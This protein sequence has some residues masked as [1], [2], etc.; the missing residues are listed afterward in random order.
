MV[1]HKHILNYISHTADA[2]CIHNKDVMVTWV[3]I[4]HDLGLIYGIL[5]P[6]IQG[7]SCYLMTPL[8]FVQQPVRWLKA[9]SKYKGTLTSGPNFS[10]DLCTDKVTEAD[11]KSID[12]SHL[13]VLLNGAEPVRKDTLL[14]FVEAFKPCG[15][16]LE[17][18]SPA[19]G[20]AEA[21]LTLNTTP[22]YKAPV[23]IDVIESDLQK[24]IV[25]TATADRT[26]DVHTFIGHSVAVGNN[27]VVIVNP[28][29]CKKCT[30]NEVGEIWIKGD[31]V[32][33][34]YWKR[35]KLSNTEFR[36]KINGDKTGDTYLRSGDL[37]FIK[38]SELFITGRHKDLI[39]IRGQ[40]YYPQDIEHITDHA[41]PALRK[42]CA[43]AFSV[44]VDREEKLIIVQEL[45][46]NETPVDTIKAII[47]QINQE[48]FD[49]F[50]IQAHALLFI[51]P[52][53]ICKTSSGK[54]QRQLCK[55]QFNNQLF[56]VVYKWSAKDGLE[57]LAKKAIPTNTALFTK[58]KKHTDLIALIA[59]I[60]KTDANT[61]VADEP[62]SFYGM[63][64]LKAV[65]I[66]RKIT[67]AYNLNDYPHLTY[68]YPSIDQ[69][70]NFISAQGKPEVTD[71]VPEVNLT[72]HQTIAITGMACRF[73]GAD[74]PAAFYE[75]LM[76]GKSGIQEIPEKR[77]AYFQLN[78]EATHLSRAG[79][80]NTV[81]DFDYRAF[82]LSKVE[83]MNMDPHQRLTLQLV[84]EALENAG[85]RHAAVSGKS[86]GVFIG[87]CTTD[88]NKLKVRNG[89]VSTGHSGTSA[90]A[91]IIANR[92][93]YFFNFKGPSLTIDT[94]CSSSLTAFHYAVESLKNGDCEIAIAGGVNLILDPHTTQ[95]YFN[96][97]MLSADCECKTFD[98]G[99]N[100]YVRGEGCG[101]VVLAT[102]NAV[103]AYNLS[104]I[105]TVAAT[106]VNQDGKSNGI[107]APN[108]PAQQ[109]VII[110][111]L[112]KA[113]LHAND[114]D[115]IET[116]GTGTKLGDPIEYHSLKNVFSARK[117]QLKLGALKTN[118]GHL[119]AA[120][121]IAGVI[122]SVLILKYNEI[123]PNRNLQI[124]NQYIEFDDKLV[125]LTKP[126]PFSPNGVK[127]RVMGISSFGFGGTN[128]HAILQGLN[129]AKPTNLSTPKKLILTSNKSEAG[130]KKQLKRLSDWIQEE[131]YSIAEIEHYALQNNQHFN[132]RGF[133]TVDAN[134][135][136]KSQFGSVLPHNNTA[137]IFSGQGSQ[138]AGMGSDLYAMY[139]T[140]KYAANECAALFNGY[141]KK[142]I[143][144]ILF[145]REENEAINE[146]NFTQPALFTFEYALCKLI[147]S[148]GIT[149]TV[150]IGH[151]IGELTAAAIAGVI[152]LQDAVELV[153]YRGEYMH[154]THETGKMLAV[155][156]EKTAFETVLTNYKSDVVIAAIN[157]VDNY[158]LS[159]KTSAILEIEKQLADKKIHT[160]LLKTSNAFHSPL[161]N[162]AALKIKEKINTIVFK[163][164]SIPIVSTVTAKPTITF[165]TDYWVNQVLS[166]VQFYPAVETAIETCDINTFIEIGP[167]NSLLKFIPNPKNE[168]RTIAAQNGAQE[169]E[170][171]S[172]NKAIGQ[173][174]INGQP[175]LLEKFFNH[176]IQ[177]VQ[178][179]EPLYQFNDTPLIPDFF[180]NSSSMPI[181]STTNNVVAA[182]N[183]T[184]TSITTILAQLLRETPENLNPTTPFLEMGADSVI[185]IG[186]TR[187][188]AN[189]FGVEISIKMLFEELPTLQKLAEYITTNTTKKTIE[190]PASATPDLPLL[191]E[192]N[193]NC[194]VELKTPPNPTPQKTKTVQVN[195]DSITQ[196]NSGVEEIIQTQLR[197]MQTQLE[198]LQQNKNH[199]S[200]AINSE[201][202][203]APLNGVSIT[204]NG[205]ATPQFFSKEYIPPVASKMV[206]TTN[207]TLSEKQQ[208]ALDQLIT[209]YTKKTATSKKLTQ[210][211][212]A[213]LAD[214][215]A[216]VGFKHFIKEM[217]YPIIGKNTEKAYVTDADQNTYID[218]T[219]GF[220]VHLFGHKPPQIIAA[221]QRELTDGTELGPRPAIAGEVAQ[222]ITKLTG[223][224]RV[225]FTNSGTEAIMTAIRLVRAKRKK[226]KIVTFSSAY[227][228][229]SDATLG[230][231]NSLNPTESLSL[232]AGI[233][234]NIMK[235]LMVLKY[236]D[237]ESL[238][239]IKEHAAELAGVLVEPIQSRRP[240]LQPTAFLKELR[241][242]TA[243]F[244]IPLVFDE[245]VTGFRVAKGGVQELFDIKADLTT[246]GKIVGGGM[247]IGVVAGSKELMDAIDGGFWQYG[248]ASYPTVETTFFG[249]TFCQHPMALTAA[250]ETLKLLDA[251]GDQLLPWLNLRTE[252]LA[253]VLNAFF[254]ENEIPLRIVQFSSLFRFAYKGNMEVLFYYLMLNGLFV[255]EWR[256]FFL[257]A[258]HTDDDLN[259]IIHA[260][261][262]SV[263]TMQKAGFI[264]GNLPQDKQPEKIHYFQHEFIDFLAQATVNAPAFVPDKT[265]QKPVKNSPLSIYFFGNYP[266]EYS[267]DKYDTLIET[268]TFADEN[269]FQA[270]WLPERHFDQFGGFSPNP[271][272]VAAALA[273]KTKNIDL[274]AGSIVLP[275][276][277]TVRAVEEWAVV[278]NLSQGR[279]G[280]AIAS[281]W[282]P[283]DFIFNP[284]TFGEHRQKT[285]T[286]LK[287]FQRIWK[288][289]TFNAKNGKGDATDLTI[290]PHPK[291]KDVPLWLTIVNNTETYKKAGEL[292]VG[293]LT[294][295]MGQSLADL[296]KNIAVYHESLVK[297]G[298][299]LQKAKVTIL[300]HAYLA[301][302]DQTATAFATPYLKD[303]LK[304]TNLLISK[305]NNAE[306]SA[307]D[308]EYIISKAVN[309]YIANKSL[310]GSVETCQK[311]VDEWLKK[312]I[313]E[314]ALFLD[315]GIPK[316][317]IQQSFEFLQQLNFKF[318]QAST[319]KIHK[320]PINTAQK[321]LAILDALD[322][323]A[324]KAYYESFSL[325]VQGALNKPAFE[326]ALHSICQRHEALRTVIKNNEQ[327]VLDTLK[328]T[329]T[330]YDLTEKNNATDATEQWYQK[331][332]NTDFS[333]ED[334]PLWR[335][336]L[337]K[338]TEK[339]WHVYFT[340]HH[341]LFDGFSVGILLDELACY[342]NALLKNETTR[343]PDPVPFRK[344]IEVQSSWLK[345][346]EAIAQKKYWEAELN[347][348]IMPLNLP[349]TYSDANKND[350][351]SIAVYFPTSVYNAIKQV[352]IQN[353]CT[354][355]STLAAIFSMLMARVC[356]QETFILGMPVANRSRLKH[357]DR[358]IGYCS[359]VTPL[360]YTVNA[361]DTFGEHA[362]KCQERM[363]DVIE[364]YQD[365]PFA[366]LLE[367]VKEQYN[368]RNPLV[369]ATF[370]TERVFMPSFD[371]LGV[372]IKPKKITHV[373]FDLRVDILE[374]EAEVL[375]SIGYKKARFSVDFI[376]GLKD[377]FM[378]LCQQVVKHPT[379]TLK[380]LEMVS[381]TAE[382]LKLGEGEKINVSFEP[383]TQQI[384][385]AV[386]LNLEKN[387]VF[388]ENNQLTYAELNKKSERVAH[389]LIQDGVKK[390]AVIGIYMSR[391]VEF[392][393]T[394][395][396]ILKAGGVYLP[397]DPA[398]PEKRVEYIS[399]DSKADR[400]IANAHSNFKQ[401][402]KK[403]VL[404][405]EIEAIKTVKTH[406]LPTLFEND[407]AYIIYTS[408]ST[409][410]PKGVRV[411]HGGLA[412]LIFWNNTHY[413][414][415]QSTVAFQ[416]A[417]VS[418]DASV[419]ELWPYLAAGASVC[420]FPAEKMIDPKK[421]VT[422]LQK[423][424]V[425][426]AFIPTALVKSVV[427]ANWNKNN[428]LKHILT[429]GD[430][431]DVLPSKKLPFTIHNNYGPTEA[432]VVATTCEVTLGETPTI[433]RPITNTAVRIVDAYGRVTPVGVCGELQL[434]GKGVS[435][436]YLDDELTAK[437][438]IANNYNERAYRTG[439]RGYFDN[440]GNIHFAGRKDDQIQLRGYRI[441]LGEIET[442]LCGHET[443]QEAK[444]YLEIDSK[445]L[446]TEMVAYVYS[447]NKNLN[448]KALQFHLKKHI[449]PY[450]IPSVF[451][452]TTGPFE[453]N[454]H[455][456][457]DIERIK[458]QKKRAIDKKPEDAKP[459]TAVE[460]ELLSIWQQTLDRKNIALTDDFFLIGGHS[461]IAVE[462]IDQINRTF[463]AKFSISILITH[464]TIRQLANAI[465][466]KDE[467]IEQTI[468]PLN[469]N[470]NETTEQLLLFAPI[471]GN[472]MCYSSLAK[473]LA[474][475][476]YGIT[477]P[478]LTDEG[479]DIHHFDALVDF[480][481]EKIKTYFADTEKTVHI[482]GFC[483]GGLLALSVYQKLKNTFAFHGQ[484]LL[485]DTS[486]PDE[487]LEDNLH[488]QNDKHLLLDDFYKDL[489]VQN[490]RTVQ[491]L[492]EELCQLN[493]T[494]QISFIHKKAIEEKLVSEKTSEATVQHLFEAF[495][496]N[497]TAILPFIPEK[498]EEHILL[499]KAVKI[500]PN[501]LTVPAFHAPDLDWCN[502]NKGI[503][504]VIDVPGNH[505]TMLNTINS[506][507]L[508]SAIN[509]SLKTLNQCI[510]EH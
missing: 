494:Q 132:W 197:L 293:V 8:D 88:F 54:I 310:I 295:L 427:S 131:H 267:A 242:L 372:Q 280:L 333:L 255:W 264:T 190:Q 63:D 215:K 217:L 445:K 142:D 38:D 102:N 9:L 462:M 32:T 135:I 489:C 400:I 117:N 144:K 405:N 5:L 113:K 357:A 199:R 328:P 218:I 350:A 233:P 20:Q 469:A 263:W 463:N 115:Y 106:A 140:F 47:H 125:P 247:P 418:F 413:G 77:K 151:S 238:A 82:N 91:S 363:F 359:H 253:N 490:G 458:R 422:A 307:E 59:P 14:R 477:S 338:T 365:Y 69:I 183:T 296:E 406:E 27:A 66:S 219:M 504:E 84:W 325:T 248:D 348:A 118:V 121:G 347:E 175:I 103:K 366:E 95:D 282:H 497:A 33:N 341:I 309:E 377:G 354:S 461:L 373:P 206:E 399:N 143:R 480:Y 173:L 401:P 46:S 22:A 431:L 455:G 428:T 159:G 457:V 243:E 275:L 165:T 154:N 128:V 346:A 452:F 503:T 133:T 201:K 19:W 274:R 403:F 262:Q 444:V 453:Q 311:K 250:F 78:G 120:A 266:A 259:A 486:A 43:A 70:A 192:N 388:Y 67:V 302:D 137:F 209:D 342:Y 184:L 55:K 472:V 171:L 116:H 426:I 319:K 336:A 232:S 499:Y 227:H 498:F 13:K 86:V 337:L 166:A 460:A 456:K 313:T 438:F 109:E 367:D 281:G 237:L 464:N 65:E 21:T 483:A 194:P 435:P 44:D 4:H 478:F 230:I 110:S 75:L 40:N 450:M 147:M 287:D 161:L 510:L 34:G 221:L 134:G 303:Y 196:N 334:G 187:Q 270:F 327:V 80:L 122:K 467:A 222:L 491:D 41:H 451:N 93:S 368:T 384:E 425:E 482:G 260:I 223:N 492:A 395:L 164:A 17:M 74:N 329:I 298:H 207:R 410:K 278:D 299:G 155:F 356:E 104:P 304:K 58:N 228:G 10:F 353:G 507:Q 149:P 493:E 105:A 449:P 355:S 6:V 424:K 381:D 87:A 437:N 383:I 404:L 371:G 414:I 389:Y 390:G 495:Y 114:I 344:F 500:A 1:C 330:F 326:A 127:K 100:G 380:E 229:H 436:G 240:E 277:H 442:V 204:K 340:A 364:N 208:N 376:R 162:E 362:K 163:P 300:V 476:V 265:I 416:M 119:E 224:E 214:S 434:V 291:Q 200:A 294:N 256:N 186:A 239:I 216:A 370:N 484:L 26:E 396:G 471:G 305:G 345:S 241:A 123:P 211:H 316:N 245:M 124:P 508:A 415:S 7:I 90:A 28:V 474:F 2:Y 468:I 35:E 79:W 446:M 351:D 360:R 369:Q 45:R 76:Q 285:F 42:G 39:I 402:H 130:I 429:G 61:M 11:K 50:E 393:Y 62:L 249:G 193:T 421:V 386:Q 443:V 180:T 60:L 191:D 470:T 392:V 18:F 349:Y 146:T 98:N 501:L 332:A 252:K 419:W 172:F 379:L 129:K 323:E 465:A 335:V 181:N 141:L 375:F 473:E 417:A 382:M 16:T 92:V 306:M 85:I 145:E 94:A 440:A 448:A 420:Q 157:G 126:F 15:V 312:G 292:G 150:L 411:T 101:I 447:T 439:D 288:T 168:L 148:F 234:D 185:L 97:G 269:Y 284:T 459:S 301:A 48:L 273:V 31:M 506:P 68:D 188:I 441:E 83:A 317:D 81:F 182:K 261:K 505:N 156:A 286:Q 290:H 432:T 71:D 160:V 502:Y 409:G 30:A 321:Q 339:N 331:W 36:A 466:R 283:N 25:T 139:P 433:G 152:E 398:L 205:N 479:Q 343:L 89:S 268:A 138:Y 210:H 412:N 52:Q 236:D 37:G 153:Y 361:D 167:R 195:D 158:V 423:N 136:L 179:D 198:L 257:S 23:F 509:Q 385:K 107:T 72:T 170:C 96:A 108:G 314:V 246:Y 308:E 276:H 297:H 64:S 485:L 279:T 231:Y 213:T 254:E 56:D 111:A 51:Q 177:S 378:G 324:S 408:G 212:R 203:S 189:E 29:S 358:M 169:N 226:S 174:Y 496:K 202:K 225:V 57:H 352:G 3:P 391:S 454:T 235:D 374:T 488:G 397:I 12:L 430:K 244:D 481:V 220:G 49:T 387:A 320:A 112:K 318:T 178:L 176:P 487:I 272:V 258:A 315:F 99:A 53:T 271:S 24:G 394:A 475:E 73:P 407:L 289:T 251:K 322:K